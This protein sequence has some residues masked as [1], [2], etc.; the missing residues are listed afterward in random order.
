[1]IIN[2]PTSEDLNRAAL[3]LYFT[4]WASLMEIA[5]DFELEYPEDSGEWS[6]EKTEYLDC[7]QS[8]LQS[9]C[10]L[11]QQSNELALKARIAEVSPFLLLFRNDRKLRVKPED[12]D[13]S[14]LRTLDAYDLPRA[15]NSFCA[16]PL[17]ETFIADYEF[18]RGLRN[19]IIHLGSVDQQFEPDALLKLM[20]RQFIELWPGRGWLAERLKYARSSRSAFFDDGK[21]RS[22]EGDVLSELEKT[23]TR[24][25]KS[26]FKRLIGFE[27]SERRYLCPSCVYDSHIRN[28]GIDL[29]ECRSAFLIIDAGVVRCAMC[30][31]DYQVTREICEIYECNGDVISK[32]MCLTCGE[33]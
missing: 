15:V 13:F 11:M 22:A 19:K 6:Q 7:C 30:E 21:W 10:T 5:A 23:F 9:C 24:F 2:V 4:A 25:T 20:I 31:Q 29:S 32:G 27:K 28:T 1:M 3:R 26:E 12:V 33:G 8:D 16:H 18:V 14:D 17:N